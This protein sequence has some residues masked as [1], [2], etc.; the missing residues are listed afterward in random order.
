MPSDQKQENA[1]AP[2]LPLSMTVVAASDNPEEWP[3][4]ST[5]I[6]IE[7]LFCDGYTYT[8]KRTHETSGVEYWR[9]TGRNTWK[10]YECIQVKN[11]DGVKV[12]FAKPPEHPKH[13]PE[14][15]G[16]QKMDEVV[17]ERRK[18]EG[19]GEMRSAAD[20]EEIQER[21]NQYTR[22]VFGEVRNF[23]SIE[24]APAAD[25]H[26]GL[27]WR[28]SG[29]KG[30]NWARTQLQWCAYLNVNRKRISK[31]VRPKDLS[32]TEI[33]KARI[34]AI[35][36]RKEI[37]NKDVSFQSWNSPSMGADTDDEDEHKDTEDKDPLTKRAPKTVEQAAKVGSRPESQAVLAEA[38]KE[39]LKRKLE[40]ILAR[41]EIAAKSFDAQCCAREPADADP[42][43]G[44]P[45]QCHIS[46]RVP[47]NFSSRK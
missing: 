14:L 18:E 40:A 44:R 33:E 11:V 46:F 35:A 6:A 15:E 23:R 19:D 5:T 29:V 42:A 20:Y 25:R 38:R 8:Y 24:A 36:L 9:C 2:P 3:E 43:Q 4:L 7:K 32:P 17:E 10:C 21:V 26:C 22:T 31:Y 34:A 45:V 28:A 41:P 27:A 13:D 30:V 47:V 1:Q 16:G 12:L 37:K 39:G